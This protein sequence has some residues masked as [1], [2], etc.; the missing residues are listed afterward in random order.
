MLAG[1][2]PEPPAPVLLTRADGH[3]MF[4]EAQVN[5]LFGDAESGKTLIESPRV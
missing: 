5:L 3:A 2:L 1:G 4:Y